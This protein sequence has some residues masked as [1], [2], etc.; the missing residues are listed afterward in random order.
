MIIFA[1]NTIKDWNDL[2]DD[3]KNMIAHGAGE[4]SATFKKDACAQ[5]HLLGMALMVKNLGKFGTTMLALAPGEAKVTAIS[6][7]KSKTSK[8][9]ASEKDGGSDT[10]DEKQ[11]H[12]I[13]VAASQGTLPNKLPGVKWERSF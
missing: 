11:Q 5:N 3:D 1:C 4:T 9:M 2:L 7:N 10:K 13:D 12:E 8:G 6:N